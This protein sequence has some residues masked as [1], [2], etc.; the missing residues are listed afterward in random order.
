LAAGNFLCDL[1]GIQI[2]DETILYLDRQQIRDLAVGNRYR[3]DILVRPTV[4]D[5][6]AG[7][8]PVLDR[9]IEV[10]KAAPVSASAAGARTG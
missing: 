1:Q 10:L 6:V 9:A 2:L 4:A 8:D 7:R 5:V 3:P